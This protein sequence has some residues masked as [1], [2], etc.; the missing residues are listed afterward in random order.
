MSPIH[1]IRVTAEHLPR[2]AQEFVYSIAGNELVFTREVK[3]LKAF[4]LACRG[5]IIEQPV[6]AK[7]SFEQLELNYHGTAPFANSLR[8]VKF[9]RSGDFAQLNVDD[10]PACQMSLSKRRIH[11]INGAEFDSE[12]NLELLTGPALILLLAQQNI[13][14]LH[15]GAVSMPSG[16]IAIIAESGVGKSTLSKHHGDAWGQLS[17]DILPVKGLILL[18]DFPQLKLL[19]ATTLEKLGTDTRLKAIFRINTS[20]TKDIHF[21]PLNA[22]EAML[23]VVRHTVA[24]KLFDQNLLSAQAAFAKNLVSD[25]PVIE[26]SYSRDLSRLDELRQAISNFVSAL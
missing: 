4:F 8:D 2:G 7:A 9:Y 6:F 3:R 20:A 23:Q 11:V 26:V 5:S 17:D 21:K 15:A 16:N 19:N 13:F 25:I 10:V 12:I 18:P 22:M 24:S 1:P 14:C